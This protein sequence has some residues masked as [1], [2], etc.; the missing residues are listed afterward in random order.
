M[1]ERCSMINEEG[2]EKRLGMATVS[3]LFRS[4]GRT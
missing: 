3:K 2:K 1:K 4:I